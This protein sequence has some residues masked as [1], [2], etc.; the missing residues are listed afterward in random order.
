MLTL[1]FKWHDK[2]LR[3]YKI[4][5]QFAFQIELKGRYWFKSFKM[6]IHGVPDTDYSIIK[7]PL[8]TGRLEKW[9]VQHLWTSL[10]TP[11]YFSSLDELGGKVLRH[12]G[13]KALKGHDSVPKV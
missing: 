10:G 12:A 8:T 4:L 7:R 11:A 3:I 5:D 6:A 13:S 9:N 1:K 2:N